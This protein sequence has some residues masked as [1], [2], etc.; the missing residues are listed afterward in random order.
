[1]LDPAFRAQQPTEAE[2]AE[3]AAL[4]AEEEAWRQRVAEAAAA[5][6]RANREPIGPA[7]STV[8]WIGRRKPG[9][10]FAIPLQAIASRD[11]AKAAFVRLTDEHSK[12]LGAINDRR[13]AIQ[14]RRHARAAEIGRSEAA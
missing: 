14:A 7:P 1:M 2:L 11:V 10:Q 12:A 5:Y 8:D 4:D 6:Q 3:L 9:R 13:L